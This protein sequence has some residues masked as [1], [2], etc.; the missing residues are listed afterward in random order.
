MALT[1]TGALTLKQYSV[2]G[3]HEES[4]GYTNQNLFLDT[5]DSKAKATSLKNFITGVNALTN[6]AT[7]DVMV[8]YTKSLT[9]IIGT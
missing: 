1:L 3:T 8:T 5:D 4:L 7:E 9:E 6:Y 2:N